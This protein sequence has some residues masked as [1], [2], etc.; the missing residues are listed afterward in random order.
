MSSPQRSCDAAFPASM[1]LQLPSLSMLSNPLP[2]V[3]AKQSS[4]PIQPDVKYEAPD[5]DVQ[6]LQENYKIVI[7]YT[8]EVSQNDLQMI[9]RHGKVIKFNSSLINVDLKTINGDYILCDA[10]DQACLQSLEPHFNNDKDRID[11]CCYCHFFEKEHFEQMHCFSSFK[12]AKDK[13]SFDFLLL[14]KKNFKKPN[15]LMSCAY[16]LVNFISKLKK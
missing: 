2:P 9:Q 1:S 14:N 15:T 4:A 16:F 12:D 5:E 13:N 8:K 11:F 3:L 10:N 6:P 7:M